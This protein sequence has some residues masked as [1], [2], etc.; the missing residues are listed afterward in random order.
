MC[1]RCAVVCQ[2]SVWSWWPFLLVTNQRLT[3]DWRSRE[4][5][6]S[7]VEQCLLIV[8]VFRK[9]IRLLKANNS[10]ED[11]SS[12]SSD[13]DDKSRAK[14][15]N[16]FTGK[17]TIETMERKSTMV[18]PTSVY[19]D[20]LASSATH[21]TMSSGQSSPAGGD[22][23]AN[24][25]EVSNNN[26]WSRHVTSDQ[27]RQQQLLQTVVKNIW[28]LTLIM[29]RLREQS[30]WKTLLI[31][32]TAT[33]A[34]VMVPHSPATTSLPRTMTRTA[35][36]F[37]WSSQGGSN[38]SRLTR[39]NPPTTSPPESSTTRLITMSVLRESSGKH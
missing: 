36:T 32:T 4:G 33:T 10:D 17:R 11:S 18:F 19:L 28:C 31:I 12:N 7:G 15:G 20:N 35:L 16:W 13:Q 23:H 6:L 38:S 21:S 3:T 5:W 29:F 26:I 2:Y 37:I 39:T 1:D 34:A 30:R 24:M 9:H 22:K 25:F 27:S 14:L 8:I